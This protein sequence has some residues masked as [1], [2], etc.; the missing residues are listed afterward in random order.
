MHVRPIAHDD[1]PAVQALLVEGGWEQRAADLARFAELVARSQVALVAVVDDAVVGFVRGLTD[2]ISNG[3]ISML[4]VDPQHR[5]RGIGSALVRACM[6]D[7]PDMTWV[8]R[9]A[10]MGVVSF[11]EKLGF[12]V[13]TVAMERPRRRVGER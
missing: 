9:A 4:V 5:K 8:L 6:G 11:Y 3:Y 2:G 7:N 10:R 12:T 1:L 13:S